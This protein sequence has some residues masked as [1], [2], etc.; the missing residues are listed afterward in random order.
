MPTVAATILVTTDQAYERVR[1]ILTNVGAT[2]WEVHTVADALITADLRGQHS[3][4]VMRLPTIVGRVRADLI[5]P[6]AEPTV[7]QM[8]PG[9]AIV[10]A[11]RGFGHATASA[12]TK[13]AQDLASQ[14]GIGLVGIRDNNH[15]GMLG[16]YAEMAARAG[17]VTIISTTTEA[18]VHPY[19]GS[20]RLLG[21][22]PIAIGVPASPQPFVLDFSTSATAIG[23]II[24]SEQRG[25]EIPVDWALDT[26]GNATS[27]PTEALAGS[28]NPFGGAKGYGLGL[29]VAL[30][31][32]LMIDTAPNPEVVG[33][34]DTINAA[35]KGDLIVAVDPKV[36]PNG[37]TFFD[38]SSELLQVIRDSRPEP[39]RER[40][41]VAGDRGR[42]HSELGKSEG[43]VLPLALWLE[44]ERLSEEAA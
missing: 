4:G 1:R 13:I 19:G 5:R 3:H 6:G 35:N 44:L 31:A 28:I 25:V 27:S 16:Y 41:M 36:M 12:A 29:A 43:V 33:T 9:V 42:L 15:I 14:V 22:N 37:V 23:K 2:E 40:V 24:D 32:G 10:E 18:M 20:D 26:N 11:A 17:Y 39:G 7:L 30:L 8:A 21:T 34:L 38:R